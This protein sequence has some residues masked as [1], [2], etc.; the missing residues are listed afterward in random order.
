[1]AVGYGIRARGS[2]KC[3]KV[4]LSGSE[5]NISMH[6][7]SITERVV[8]LCSETRI[9]SGSLVRDV[10]DEKREWEFS[11]RAL[12]N[13][14]ENTVDGGMGVQSWR[15]L[16]YAA[17]SNTLVLKKP[18]EE[19]TELA[20]TVMIKPDSYEEAVRSRRGNNW[21]SDIKISLVEV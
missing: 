1:M 20:Y 5:K 16:V 2:G 17:M 14:D 15:D 3:Y 10:I 4:G 13:R 9:A 21:L 8:L 7:R 12:P 18:T 11:F 6:N 19:G